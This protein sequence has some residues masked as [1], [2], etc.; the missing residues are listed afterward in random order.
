M[1]IIVDYTT[2][3]TA[4]SDYLVRSDLSSFVAGFIQ[5]WEERFYR[6]PKN[7][8]NW[9]ESSLNSTIASSVIAVPDDY[10]ALKYAYVDG[11]PAS[12]LDRVSLNQI[13]GTFPRGGGT[14]R[15]SWIAR[16]ATN[17][18]FGPEPDDE[19]T[20]K[21]VYWAKPEL[22]RSFAGDAAAHWI[23]VNAPDLPLYGALLEATP[24]LQNDKRIP[25]W[26]GF[27]DM[28]LRDYRD[29]F[30]KEDVSGS[31]VMEVLA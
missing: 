26:Q 28:A 16:D 7:F 21:G 13:Y 10:L 4:V 1:A 20:I 22:M 3:Q 25:T 9:M 19:Y 30:K 15:P 27:Y 18:V 14:G 24:F 2:L 17:F 23:I 29:L 11:S 8:G 12:R 6:Q 5:N 31:P